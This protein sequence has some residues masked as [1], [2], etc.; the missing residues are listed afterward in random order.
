ML[1]NFKINKESFMDKFEAAKYNLSN[2]ITFE[3]TAHMIDIII[4]KINDE[5]IEK[6]RKSSHVVPVT[7]Q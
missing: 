6:N 3:N 1:T 7:K 5:L 4:N 2:E